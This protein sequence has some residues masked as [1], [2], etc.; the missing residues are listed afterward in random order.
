MT[1]TRIF[2]AV[3]G[4]LVRPSN[5]SRG[6][7]HRLGTEHVKSSTLS[8]IPKRTRNAVA[9]FE[10]MDDRVLHENV[11][12]KMDAMVLQSANHLEA[13]TV[14]DMGQAR[15]SMTA[16]IT[17]QDPTIARAVEKGTPRFQLADACR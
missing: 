8:V 14:T 10:Q 6:E 5:S 4:D 13:R 1:V 3:A 7:D 16:E 11:Y 17:L 12:T 9:V 15:I 2:P